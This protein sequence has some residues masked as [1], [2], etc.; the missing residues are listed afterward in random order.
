MN[1]MPRLTTVETYQAWRADS[2]RCLAAALEIARSHG[3]SH[4]S[5]H[6]FPTGTNLVVAL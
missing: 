1:S 2:S 4:Q 3:L 6:L 5:P